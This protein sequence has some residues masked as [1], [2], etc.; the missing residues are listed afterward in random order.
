MVVYL[1]GRDL[2]QVGLIFFLYPCIFIG[3]I[4]KQEKQRY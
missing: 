1:V 2:K 4:K 3:V